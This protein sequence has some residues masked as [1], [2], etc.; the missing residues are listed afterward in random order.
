[1]LMLRFPKNVWVI[2]ITS[3]LLLS[4]VTMVIL[5]G[6][7]IG[8]SL[9]PNPKLA[10]LPIAAMV[11]GTALCTLPTAWILKKLGRKAGTYIGFG[12]SFLSIIVALSAIQLHSFILYTASSFFIGVGV[13]FYHQFRFAILESLANIK[14]SG[15]ALSILMLCNIVG[16]MIGPELVALSKIMLPSIGHL[17]ASYYLFGGLVIAAACVF[18]LFKN[19]TFTEEKTTGAPRPFRALVRQPLFLTA[20]GAGAIGYGFMTFIMTSTPLSMHHDHGFSITEAK[21]VIQ[22]HLLAMFLPSFFSG[23]LIKHLGA[24]W[25]MLLGAAC[26]IAVIITALAGQAF[27]HYWWALVLLGVGWNFLF[28]SGTTLLPQSYQHNERFKAQAI[29]DFTVFSI[30]A[31]AALSAA[32]ILL[33]FGWHTQVLIGLPFT[34]LLIFAACKL[35]KKSGLETADEPDAR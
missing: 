6:G 21:W 13:A 22:C 30:Q 32:W 28:L 3:A 10:T 8:H 31:I 9:A 20:V 16:A 26:Y 5:I 17:G 2:S 24:V 35:A 4:G 18:L 29:N 11:V 14:D 33:T 23:L 25:V 19:P 12:F 27:I 15:P 34:L 7:L 1:M